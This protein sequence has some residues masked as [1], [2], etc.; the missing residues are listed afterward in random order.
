MLHD[1]GLK[2][3]EGRFADCKQKPLKSK[4]ELF[5]TPLYKCIEEWENLKF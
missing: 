1:L 3:T 4:E 2:P 5:E